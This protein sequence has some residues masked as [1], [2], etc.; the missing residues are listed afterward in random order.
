MKPAQLGGKLQAQIARFSGKLSKGLGKVAGR[1]VGEVLY[2]MQARGSVK[3]SEIGRALEEETP[4]KKVI[5]R[6]GRQLERRGV[7]E[8][9][10]RNHLAEAAGRITGESLLVADPTDIT[11]PYARKM[12]HQAPVRDGSTGEIGEG[13][14]CFQVVAAR[15]DSATVV[16]LYQELYSQRAPGFLSE[17]EEMKRGMA[18][19]A[20]VTG[21]RGTWVVDRGGDRGELLDWFLERGESF[22]I[23]MRGDRHVRW[24][25]STR[26]MEEVAARVRRVGRHTVTKETARGERVLELCYG[27]AQVRLPGHQH[28]ALT[29]L[30]VDGVGEEPLLVLTDWSVGRS[31]RRMRKVLE[32]Y[33]ARWRVEETIRFIKQSYELEDIRILTYERLQTM[34]VLV[35][36]AAY[37]VCMELGEQLRLR[38]MVENVLEA[39]QRIFGIP[40]FRYYALADGLKEILFNRRKPAAEVLE[41]PPCS[42]LELPLAT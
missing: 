41:R 25:R 28:K 34:A 40:E 6:L 5:E 36:A 16:P 42:E 14:W 26:S 23:R 17:N 31:K 24:G 38:V 8:R 18:A 7:R 9:V 39:A 3:L 32:S 22:L 1:M 19:V 35:M 27:T 4:L 20:E 30:V 12:E 11:K 21:G 15:R 2:G 10:R 13:Y 33:L 37:F 29:L